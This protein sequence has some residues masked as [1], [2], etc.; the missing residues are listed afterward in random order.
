MWK[1]LARNHVFRTCDSDSI[2]PLIDKAIRIVVSDKVDPSLCVWITWITVLSCTL[3]DDGAFYVSF[4]LSDIIRS[5]NTLNLRNFYVTELLFSCTFPTWTVDSARKRQYPLLVLSDMDHTTTPPAAPC[6]EPAMPTI[7]FPTGLRGIFLP[8]QSL[9][10]SMSFCPLGSSCAKRS[11]ERSLVS[12]LANFDRLWQHPQMNRAMD[13]QS[14]S[15]WIDNLQ[16]RNGV[17]VFRKVELS[18]K[19]NPVRVCRP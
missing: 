5:R 18:K 4:I 17:S 2:L 11:N 12:A 10:F 1:L 9:R 15:T 14:S 8:F 13:P 19:N 16:F 6:P 7:Y 3:C